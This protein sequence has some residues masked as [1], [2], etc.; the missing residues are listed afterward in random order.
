VDRPYERLSKTR[1]SAF[2]R[3]GLENSLGA[4]GSIDELIVTGVCT[5]ICIF[6]TALDARYR[7]LK[8][9]IPRDCVFPLDRERGE[10]L[11]KFLQD[12]AGVELR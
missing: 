8:V 10:R 11:L 9:V 5:D 4:L 7:D 1:F 2:F 12:V 6:A 3:T